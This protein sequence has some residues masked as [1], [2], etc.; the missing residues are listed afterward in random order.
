MSKSKS[1]PK[2]KHLNALYR[3]HQNDG[4]PNLPLGDRRADHANYTEMEQLEKHM[5]RRNDD[6][7]RFN[8]FHRRRC[9]NKPAK[10]RWHNWQRER[11]RERT[12]SRAKRLAK[13]KANGN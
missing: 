12:F 5:V 9:L 6:Q 11:K 8:V 3:K 4:F 10:F 1:E 7:G 13:V 2:Y